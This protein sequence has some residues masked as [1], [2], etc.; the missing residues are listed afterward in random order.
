M[1]SFPLNI[2]VQSGSVA[3]FYGAVRVNFSPVFPETLEEHICVFVF[4][5]VYVFI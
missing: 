2:Y 4:A 3:L 5:H 1:F